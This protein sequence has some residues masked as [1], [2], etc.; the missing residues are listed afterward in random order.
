MKP[1][2]GIEPRHAR[3]CAVRGWEP[4]RCNPAYQAHVWS[5]KD[6]RRIRKTFP[7]LAAAKSWRLDALHALKGGTM[8]APTRDTINEAADELLAG[9]EDGSIRNRN[10]KPFKPSA[11]RSYR[12]SLTNYLRPEF[13]SVRLCDLT[14]NDVQDFVD[15][16]L[17]DGL[18][19]STVRNAI[20]PLRV[21]YRRAVRRGVVTVNPTHDLELPAVDG[22]RERVAP[23]AEATRLLDALPESDRPL[24]ATAL[25]AGLRSG[26]LEALQDE[27][28]DLDAGVLRVERAWDKCEGFIEPKSAAGK[29][30]VPICNHLRSYLEQ[31]ER[32][33]G[34]F[35]GSASKPFDYDA[36]YKRARKA[37]EDA[38]LQRIGLHE[39]RHSFST[40]LD[41]AGISETRADIY[42]GHANHSVSRRYRHPSQYV[43]DAARLDEYLSGAEAGTIVNFEERAA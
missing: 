31:V 4:C 36:T 9:M 10:R 19:P 24:W 39:C 6:G 30:T 14:R 23:P 8:R 7:T 11:I 37:W 33:G 15:A 38:G 41:A 2:P 21:V 27:N 5:K 26:E 43:E 22:R 16:L 32:N 17:A 25:Y 18:D 35:F 13:G 42:M 1:V 12:Q 20:M 34:F 40:L 3:S 28:V 29:R